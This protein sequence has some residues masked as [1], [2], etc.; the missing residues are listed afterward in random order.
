MP[1]KQNEEEEEKKREKIIL[2]FIFFWLERLNNKLEKLPVY[3]IGQVNY[4]NYLTEEKEKTQ[5]AQK[6]DK[7]TSI[8][9][10]YMKKSLPFKCNRVNKQLWFQLVTTPISLSVLFYFFFTL[11]H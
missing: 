5:N 10:L 4:T 8:N 2:N 9:E 1:L 3:L 6:W 7:Y 11:K